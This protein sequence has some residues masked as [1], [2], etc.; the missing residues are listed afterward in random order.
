[1]YT[2][3][4]LQLEDGTTMTAFSADALSTSWLDFGSVVED[5]G[6]G[7][8][9][10]LNITVTAAAGGTGTVE[11]QA[12]AQP[13][14]TLAAMTS[15][16]PTYYAGS[17][18][19][20]TWAAHGLSA[21]APYIHSASGTTVPTGVTAGKTYYVTAPTT[22][23]FSLSTTL[24]TALSGTPDATIGSAGSGTHTII[25]PPLVLGSSGK[26]N[27]GDIEVGTVIRVALNPLMARVK[28][29]QVGG[30]RYFFAK[31]VEGTASAVTAAVTSAK[32]IVD[33]TESVSAP[34][35]YPVG[36][37]VS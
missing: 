29:C 22:N 8:Q 25:I 23:T 35:Y 36:S 19:I 12:V 15:T 5:M 18:N 1:M 9:L 30:F 4:K 33:L 14:T 2:D 10:F 32:W 37:S 17:A 16:T 21:G 27:V 34:T 11:F 6:Q 31:Y 13:F 3:T 24:A 26:I 28:N 20:V 7:K